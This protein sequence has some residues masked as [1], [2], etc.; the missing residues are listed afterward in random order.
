MAAFVQRANHNM[1]FDLQTII[2][3][4]LGGSG[5]GMFAKPIAER[6]VD[7]FFNRKPLFAIS[8]H[9]LRNDW[10]IQI[11]PVNSSARYKRPLNLSFRGTVM[12]GAGQPVMGPDGPKWRLDL[13]DAELIRDELVANTLADFQLF[14]DPN[15]MSE[16]IR[17]TYKPSSSPQQIEYHSSTDVATIKSFIQG[18]SSRRTIFIRS[19]ELLVGDGF[20]T[21]TA[22]VR[23]KSVFD[24][25]ELS[26]SDVEDF[27]IQG[28][29]A[30]LLAEA[31]YS[32]VLTFVNCRNVTLSDITAG[33]LT[34]GYCM[35]GVIRF[36]GCSGVKIRRCDLYGSG[37]YGFEFVSCSDVDID[38]TTVRDC[39]YGILNI[40]N[41]RSITF[42]NCHFA[43]NREF[44]LCNFEGTVEEVMFRKCSFER[45]FSV[46]EL[47][48]FGD[49]AQRSS[50]VYVWDCT[51]NSNDCPRLQNGTSYFSESRNV[52]KGNAW[53]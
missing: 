11:L 17:V 34:A 3:A 8:P 16:M 9:V 51:F 10:S 19:A 52:Y 43:N 39:S 13:S 44:S 49:M 29:N 45:N 53:L 1:T 46:K 33:H 12:V 48:H 20:P 18:V 23:W 25:K 21:S 7:R 37:T 40:S 41:S 50:G 36:E 26:I 38:G 6:L 30:A 22:N 14:F 31:R 24:G 27:E 47:F 15:H 4:A 28:E 32:W 5:L 35:G 42:T 2:L